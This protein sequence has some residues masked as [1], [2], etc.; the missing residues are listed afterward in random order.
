MLLSTVT[1]GSGVAFSGPSLLQIFYLSGS[2]RY[3]RMQFVDIQSSPLS[4]FLYIW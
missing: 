2:S 1:D 3:G 4:L